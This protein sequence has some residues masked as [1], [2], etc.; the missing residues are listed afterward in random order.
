MHTRSA[1]LP[2]PVPTGD[3]FF[4]TIASALLLVLTFL[5]FK[6][7]YLQGQAFPGRPLTPPIRTELIVHGVSMTL[8]MLLMVAQ[9]FLVASGNKRLH[10]KLG[11]VGA[12]LAGFIVIVGL[13]VAVDAMRVAPPQMLLFGLNPHQFLTVPV[14]SIL[15][16]GGAVA[17]AV[18]KRNQPEIHRPFMWMA[19]VAA[20]GAA[21]GRMPMLNAWYANTWIEV[22]LSAFAS[23]LVIAGVLVVARMV[24]A[25]RFDRWLAVSFGSFVVWC[26]LSSLIARTGAWSA[27]AASLGS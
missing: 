12:V 27:F 15:F 23:H 5:G 3:R 24:L 20:T 18:A 7:F 10:R 1:T 21:T 22:I 2:A 16:F 8:W 11:M 4:Y 6:L 17:I 19:T 26:V 13:K 14:F 9:P 25:K